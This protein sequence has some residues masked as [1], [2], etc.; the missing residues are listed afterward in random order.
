METYSLQ[1]ILIIG[2]K[3]LIPSDT[4]LVNSYMWVKPV[5]NEVDMYCIYP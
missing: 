3:N 5:S 2:L 1:N 4:N